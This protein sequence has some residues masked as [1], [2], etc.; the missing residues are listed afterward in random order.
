VFGVGVLVL[1]FL[2]F[3]GFG[4]GGLVCGSGRHGDRER[5]LKERESK[6]SVG[7]ERECL[8]FKDTRRNS[9]MLSY[10]VFLKSQRPCLV[11]R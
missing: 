4:D 2:L 10:D 8:N 5:K 7:V 11:Q 6:K 9:F 3:L 1:F